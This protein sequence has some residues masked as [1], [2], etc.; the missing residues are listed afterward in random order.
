MSPTSSRIPFCLFSVRVNSIQR[1]TISS[2]YCCH[3]NVGKV[4]PCTCCP[5]DDPSRTSSPH[6]IIIRSKFRSHRPNGSLGSPFPTGARPRRKRARNIDVPP[7]NACSEQNPR[8]PLVDEGGVV[9][10]LTAQSV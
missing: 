9:L 3:P 7:L 6:L 5:A 4:R 8:L 2:F 10:P 1:W